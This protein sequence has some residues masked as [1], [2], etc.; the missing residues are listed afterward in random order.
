MVAVVTR[1]GVRQLSSLCTGSSVVPV[2]EGLG[3]EHRRGGG[4][5]SGRPQVVGPCPNA[6]PLETWSVP[7]CRGRRGPQTCRDTSD[8]ETGDGPFTRLRCTYSGGLRRPP[9]LPGT[10]TSR[11]PGARGFQGRSRSGTRLRL[12][13]PY[14]PTQTRPSGV[15]LHPDPSGL[16]SSPASRV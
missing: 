4:S 3:S 16:W 5:G 15:T 12:T 13:T 9:R 6:G 2:R 8:D 7:G 10:G 11:T 14:L 1:I